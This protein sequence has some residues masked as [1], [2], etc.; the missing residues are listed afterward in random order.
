M[1][2]QLSQ[3]G[4]HNAK[5]LTIRQSYF[6]TNEIT[7]AMAEKE[8]IKDKLPHVDIEERLAKLK[9]RL[10]EDEVATAANLFEGGEANLFLEQKGF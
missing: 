8:L 5:V 9:D 6:F 2:L 7:L 1:G 3:P 10:K 4:S